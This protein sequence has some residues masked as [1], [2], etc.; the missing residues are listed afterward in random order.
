MAPLAPHVVLAGGGTAGHLFPGIA[1]AKQLVRDA[2]STR[3]TFAG[4]G[5]T[6]EYERVRTAGFEYIAL[7]SSP[8]PRSA[9]EAVR[10]VTDHLRGGYLARSYLHDERVS[11]VV[12]LGSY[13]SVPMLRAAK[14]RGVPYMLLE[15]NAVPGR[16]TRWF[17][18]HA[19]LVCLAFAETFSQLPPGCRTRLT[20]N[21][22]RRGF[23]QLAQLDD[24]ERQRRARMQPR[25]LIL[26]GS[27]GARTLN[28][29]A[30][31]AIYKA[32]EA[33][34]GWDI[35]HQSGDREREATSELYRK[36]GIAATVVPFIDHMARALLESELA[37]SRAGGTTLAELATAGIPAILLPY[38][39]ATDDHQRKNADVLVA[40][41]GSLLVDEREVDGRLDD[42]L[43]AAVVKLASD[44]FLR[45]RMSEA[46]SRA[47]RPDAARSVARVIG[48]LLRAGKFAG[49]A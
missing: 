12:G 7:P 41:G 6:F 34:S 13:A 43:A 14:R 47:A 16:A 32:G 36:L 22:V 24:A 38:P 31:L 35:L 29:Q 21:P 20:G 44:A 23:A 18:P 15:Q 28:E 27:G 26:G 9:R 40:A 48:D 3:I 1:V 5:R 42:V 25:L 45:R 30:P 8:L 49:A 10:F 11:L 19:R 37:I 33:L 4:T 46:M 17:A 39:K 2:P